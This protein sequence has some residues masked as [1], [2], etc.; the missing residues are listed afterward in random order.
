MYVD[1][2][3]GG[4][5]AYNGGKVWVHR[6]VVNADVHIT[7]PA[8]KIHTFTGLTV[9]MKNNIGLYPGTIYGFAKELGVPQD[10]FRNSTMNS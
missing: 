5:A 8:L 4:Y 2:P 1:I 6:D 10:D 9:G 7:V 3:R